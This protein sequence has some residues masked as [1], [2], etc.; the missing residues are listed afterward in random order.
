VALTIHQ[1][2]KPPALEYTQLISQFDIDI[3]R[4][5]KKMAK[6]VASL[7]K[8]SFIRN[9]N[10]KLRSTYFNVDPVCYRLGVEM[11][12]HCFLRAQQ[13]IQDKTSISFLIVLKRKRNQADSNNEWRKKSWR[14]ERHNDSSS[15]IKLYEQVKIAELAI[16]K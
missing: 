2:S 8:Q 12:Q 13:H 7:F 16:K 6:G 5:D 10:V 4:V 11:L 1:R 15:R 9:N 3:K 14:P